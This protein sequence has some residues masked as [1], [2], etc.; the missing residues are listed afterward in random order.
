MEFIYC[1][2]Q[3]LRKTSV[4]WD[5]VVGIETRYELDSPGVES[6]W[7]RNFQPPSR[8]AMGHT[9]PPVQ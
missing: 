6:W 2:L 1:I 8:P 5:I 9:Q 7:G 4:G 3:D